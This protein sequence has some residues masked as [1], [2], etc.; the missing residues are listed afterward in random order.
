MLRDKIEKK[1]INYKEKNKNIYYS[2]KY[3]YV[4]RCTWKLHFLYFINKIAGKIIVFDMN[5]KAKYFIIHVR[6]SRN[7]YIYGNI[8]SLF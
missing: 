2:S 3:C 7:V 8:W 1:N 5:R 6:L 4:K